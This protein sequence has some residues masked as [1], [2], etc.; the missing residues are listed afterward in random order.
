MTFWQEKM[1]AIYDDLSVERK[2]LVIPIQLSVKE[3]VK[4]WQD[5]VYEKNLMYPD[6]LKYETEQGDIVV[7]LESLSN[8]LDIKIVKRLVKQIINSK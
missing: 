1:E 3:R 2:S 8:P 6:N 5:E 7:N 4:Q